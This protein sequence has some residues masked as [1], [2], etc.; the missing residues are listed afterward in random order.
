MSLEKPD[1]AK[2]KGRTIKASEPRELQLGAKGPKKNL[3]TCSVCGIACG[4]D[5]RTCL[6]L[7]HNRERLAALGGRRSGRPLGS[8]N[9]V[10]KFA[11]GIEVGIQEQQ[12][13]TGPRR[14]GRPVGSKNKVKEVPNAEYDEDTSRGRRVRR[15]L[16]SPM[17][18]E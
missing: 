13:S 14:R 16:N 12:T 10:T 3:K 7:E 6:K 4:H 1:K 18:V 9:K 2:P 15:R 11:D 17:D 8:R 5:A